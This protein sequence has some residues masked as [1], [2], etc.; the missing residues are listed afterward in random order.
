[1]D[2]ANQAQSEVPA[3]TGLLDNR[4]RQ[5][6]HLLLAD[7]ALFYVQILH[8][9]LEF[10]RQHELEPLHEDLF[11]AVRAPQEAAAAAPYTMDLFLQDLRQLQLWNLITCR[12]EKERLR[13]YRDTRRR[14]FRYQ[15]ADEA[16]AFLL[17]LEERRRDDLQPDEP[18]TRDVLEELVGTL[19][20]TARL[21]NRTGG[22][23]ALDL[24]G[25]RA[26]MYRLS[27]MSALTY[28]ASRSLGE[29]NVRL[30]GFVI[31][32]YDLATARILIG[33]LDHFLKRFLSRI[34]A[35]RQEIVPELGKMRHSRYHARWQ[36]CVALM[37]SERR[38]TPHLL[39]TRPHH[40]PD[41]ELD[42]LARFYAEDGTLE[43]LCAR[44][45]A[46]AL[47]VWR[48]LYAHLRELERR[49]HRLEDLQARVREIAAQPSDSTRA[50]A[51]IQ[52]LIAPA[53]MIGDM[54][55]WSET[56]KAEPPEP[57]WEKYRTRAQTSDYLGAK[58]MADGRPVQSIEE[59]RLSLLQNWM[60]H[61]GLAPEADEPVPVS[62]GAF[63]GQEDFMKLIELAR[64]GLL[65]QGARL[66]KL[67]YILTPD[68]R[69][70]KV[71]AREQSLA[72][73]ELLVGKAARVRA[74][75]KDAVKSP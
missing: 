63:A 31:G 71:Q 26:I 23:A 37:E 51:F 44:V 46:S 68:P 69:P 24:D 53:R 10:R 55:L 59:A 3:Q 5:L 60:Q 62:G 49:S 22:E 58:N 52:T 48:K 20:E 43:Q 17:W 21:L 11:D 16:T 45:N 73:N 19:R 1:M 47:L 25:A 8:R 40:D 18:D 67:G 42:T 33:E 29:F 64:H 36:S 7:R 72:F 4:C 54:H 74:Q 75:G 15:L 50:A 57:R 61:A 41:S 14:K 9:M 28:D 65:G 38:A 39:R 13:G 12:I 34:H 30:L 2:Q 66:R 27:R 70:V 32:R 56:E 6:G 35:L